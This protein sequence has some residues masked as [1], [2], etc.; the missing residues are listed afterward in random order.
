M[1]AAIKRATRIANLLGADSAQSSSSLSLDNNDGAEDDDDDVDNNGHFTHKH[2]HTTTHTQRLASSELFTSD[3]LVSFPMFALANVSVRR[4]PGL[5]TPLP[6]FPFP[7]SRACL[8]LL[9]EN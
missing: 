1:H 2:K 4:R 8:L 7:S 6:F 5:P 9:L 3:F